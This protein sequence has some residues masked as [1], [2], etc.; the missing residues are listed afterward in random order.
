MRVS[1]FVNLLLLL[2]A[3]SLAQ[4]QAG[5]L[6]RARDAKALV[7][8]KSAERQREADAAYAGERDA[9]NGAS[10]PHGLSVDLSD[11]PSAEAPI[12]VTTQGARELAAPESYTVQKGDTLWDLSRRFLDDPYTW[13]KVWAENPSIANPHFIYPGSSIR[14]PGGRQGL[15]EAAPTA[16]RE[17]DDLS[18]SDGTPIGDDDDVAVVGPYK[19]GYVPPRGLYARR[20]AFV[21]ERELAEAGVLTAAFD[22]KSMLSVGDRVYARFKTPSEVRPGQSYLFYKT[23]RPVTH[24]T[25]GLPFGYQTSILGTGRVV[26]VDARA[27][28][29]EIV[30]AF[31]PIERG[32]L[33]GPQTGKL[34]KQVP[35]RPNGKDLEGHIVAAQQAV[36]TE[37]GQHHV[38]FI[39]LGKKDGVEEG[40][41]LQVIRSG[42]L[43]ERDMKE[44]QHDP[45][46]PVEAVGTLLVVD[47]QENAS[48]ALVLQSDRELF[49]G[50]EV[51]MKAA[52]ELSAR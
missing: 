28:T 19:I 46:L 3:P 16:P 11:E 47:V 48:T 4:G 32:A 29:V 22:E 27:A 14:F 43:L 31:D 36:Q 26:A 34:V 9:R 35:R 39:D 25:T 6:Q 40:N 8:G 44:A 5:A 49:V 17:L 30:Q 23:E 10:I 7:E 41:T 18:T 42:D 13:P 50:D 37:L 12:E 21:T 33:L 15:I 51:T 45:N 1:P 24:P 20:D 38:V 2:L 52:V